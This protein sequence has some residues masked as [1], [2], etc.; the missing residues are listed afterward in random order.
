[1]LNG[2][3]VEETEVDGFE[4][5]QQTFCCSNVAHDQLVQVLVTQITFLNSFFYDFKLFYDI[6]LRL[7]GSFLTS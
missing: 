5:E 6:V 7:F 3:E 1:M 4:L 2:E